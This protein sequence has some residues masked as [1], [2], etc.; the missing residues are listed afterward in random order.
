VGAS[1]GRQLIPKVIHRLW[2]GADPVPADFERYG[3]TWARHHP[4]WEMRLW[5]DDNLPPL[6]CQA[7]ID[8]MPGFKSRYD[9]VR[10]ELL[11]QFGGVIVDLDMEA[12]RPIDP[13]LGGVRA[14][15]CRETGKER[16]IG[17]Q[18]IGAEP[19]HPLLERAVGELST[20]ITRRGAASRRA[21]P[22][23]FTQIV[24]EFRDQITIFPRETFLSP[25]TIEP[26]KRPQDFPRM[27]A[28]HHH[29][30]SWRGASPEA[31]VKRLENR[32][33]WAQAEIDVL[34]RAVDDDGSRAQLNR[35]RRDLERTRRE[36]ALV[37]GSRWWRLGRRLGIVKR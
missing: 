23:F 7:L 35:S 34:T 37:T 24:D 22:V 29:A 31:Q 32:L 28:V 36:L 26:P 14:F 15:V 10:Y 30:E 5:T 1:A 18:I 3:E 13:L 2:L 21:G 17:T 9:M 4:E 33:V 6:S 12:L 20:S 16:R 8:G 11:R 25:L 27:F 19:R